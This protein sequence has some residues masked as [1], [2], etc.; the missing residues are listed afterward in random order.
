MAELEQC[1]AEQV[2]DAV[3]AVVLATRPC[4]ASDVSDF[5]NHPGPAVENALSVAVSLGLLS[6]DGDSYSPT[7]AYE[8]YFAEASESHRIDVLRFALEGFAPYRFFKQ[9]LGFHN[10]PLRAARETK[11]RFEFT[12]H[13]G[14]I[15]ETLVSL[16]QFSGSLTYT[17]QTG[18][19]LATS[20]VADEFLAAADTVSASGASIDAFLRE[21]LGVDAYTYIQDEQDDIITHLRG[22][23]GKVVVDELEQAAVVQISNACENFLVKLADEATPAVDLTGATGI[24]SKG[25]RLKAAG[26]IAQKHMGYVTLLGQ[27]RN[28][29]DHGIDSD[30]NLDW[31]V[32]PAA[33]RL[34][35]LTVI[36]MIKSVV[37]LSLG[38]AEF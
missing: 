38:R 6:R 16:G 27:L 17:T 11:L 19:E 29:G 18:Y 8:S 26:V 20:G 30:V 36:A 23:L 9:R 2:V 21:S 1:T 10:D 15:R 24:I 31:E 12:N 32:T 34:G 25:E 7:P 4:L 13:E 14:E 22:A 28:A 33:V 37:A 3:E 35:A 5:V